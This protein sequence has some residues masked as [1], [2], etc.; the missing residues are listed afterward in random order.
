[1]HSRSK[2]RRRHL[3]SHQPLQNPAL[4]MVSAARG[5]EGQHLQPLC[6][7]QR[8][9]RLRPLGPHL[10]EP[11]PQARLPASPHV[12]LWQQNPI[13]MG[14]QRLRRLL[15]ELQEVHTG[16]RFQQSPLLE[17][18]RFFSDS[19]C[20][21]TGHLQSMRAQGRARPPRLCACAGSRA[22]EAAWSVERTV[23]PSLLGTLKVSRFG[24]AP[25]CSGSVTHCTLGLRTQHAGMAGPARPLAGLSHSAV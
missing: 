1:M 18:K 2:R 14:I 22:P 5:L 24:A 9:L 19:W 12:L 10:G 25:I 4:A 6:I 20:Y 13:S 8:R 16:N 15:C 21:R 17:P 23:T 3:A 7:L 11:T